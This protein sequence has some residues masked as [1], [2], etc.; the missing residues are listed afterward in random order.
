MTAPAIICGI[1]ANTV[2]GVPTA[3]ESVGGQRLSEMFDKPSDS[4]GDE[5]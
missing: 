2:L 4:G 1:W 5:P 3:C